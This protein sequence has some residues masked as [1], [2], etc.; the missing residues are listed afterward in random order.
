MNS[1]AAVRAASVAAASAV[2]VLSGCAP[3]AGPDGQ[4]PPPVPAYLAGVQLSEDTTPFAVNTLDRLLQ[5]DP[6]AVLDPS[7]AEQ[8][9]GQKGDAIVPGDEITSCGL[10]LVDPAN[11]DNRT[12]INLM[13][14]PFEA[15]FKTDTAPMQLPGGV[16]VYRTAMESSCIYEHDLGQ[17]FAMSVQVSVYGAAEGRPCDGGNRLM[18]AIAPRL[19]EPPTRD[20]GLTTPSVEAVSPCIA[21]KEA[22]ETVPPMPG[23]QNNDSDQKPQVSWTEPHECTV[24]DWMPHDVGDS[25]LPQQRVAV[26]MEVSEDPERFVRTGVLQPTSVEGRPGTV[27][28]PDPSDENPRCEV[29]VRMSDDV[30]IRINEDDDDGEVVSRVVQV[31]APTCDQASSVAAS[32]LRAARS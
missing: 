11:A 4:Q 6:C 3:Q 22:L 2:A 7:V 20:Q 32:T 30:M 14:E 13:V 24:E 31:E 15:R 19:A 10:D 21:I 25:A 18:N 29:A 27:R 28:P 9:L 26:T 5:L 17:G 23:N 1:R 12:N 16:T 8:A